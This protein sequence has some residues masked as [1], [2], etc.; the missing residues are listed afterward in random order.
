MSA[1]MSRTGTGWVLS[2]LT[3]KVKAQADGGCVFEESE[4]QQK[5]QIWTD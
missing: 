1:Q 2:E 5:G 3:S 4:E